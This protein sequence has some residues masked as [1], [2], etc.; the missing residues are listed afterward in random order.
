MV[1]KQ[2][3]FSQNPTSNFDFGSIS[4]QYVVQ[5]SLLRRAAVDRAAPSQ[6]HDRKGRPPTRL[7]PFHTTV[8]GFTLSIQ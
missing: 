1:Q 8:L 5:P 2:Y 7:Q 3:A 4:W 6:P